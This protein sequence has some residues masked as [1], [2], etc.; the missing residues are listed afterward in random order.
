[1]YS[2]KQA[3]DIEMNKYNKL[4]IT[5]LLLASSLSASFQIQLLN[6]TGRLATGLKMFSG[7]DS[8]SDQNISEQKDDNGKREYS[9]TWN[10]LRLAV[11][12]L[13]M[14][15]PRFLSQLNYEKRN[16]IYKCAGCGT[17]LFNSRGKYNSG[18]GWPSFWCSVDQDVI[19]L[20]KEWD[21]RIECSCSNCNGHLGHVFPDGPKSAEMGVKNLGIDDVMSALRRPG[22]QMPIR[23]P[24]F[25][26]NGGALMF[27][28]ESD[29]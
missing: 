29:D 1:L 7:G 21:G 24:R 8:E 5:V 14:T 3:V 19:K 6:R 28:E 9:G 18:S 13:G 23:L 12:K 22:G 25:C 20:T 4:L 17:V 2:I 11:L 15:E 27:E 16:G 26:M 10:P